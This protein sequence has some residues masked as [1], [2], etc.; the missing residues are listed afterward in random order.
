[1]SMWLNNSNSVIA[2]VKWHFDV[3]NNTLPKVEFIAFA[4]WWWTG[5]CEYADIVFAADSWAEF[6]HP[7]MVAS[8]SNPFVQVFPRTPLPR[9]FDSKPDIE[10]IAGVAEKLAEIIDDRRMKDMWHFVKP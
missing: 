8:G 5:S 6:K 2:N 1:K 7:D 4:D 9:I 10:I 3:V